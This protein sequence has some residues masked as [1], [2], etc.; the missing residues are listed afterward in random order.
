MLGIALVAGFAAAFAVARFPA[1]AADQTVNATAG[2]SWDPPGEVAITAGDTITWA[3]PSGGTHNVCVRPAADSSGC[4]TFRNGAPSGDWSAYT[5]EHKFTVANQSY[6]FRCE[7]HPGMTGTI[8]VGDGSPSTTTGTTPT[9]TTNAT[10]TNTTTTSASPT[11][12]LTADTTAP[13]FVGTIR[14][15]SSRKMLRLSFKVSENGTLTATLRRRPPGRKSFAFVSKTT[16]AVT[17]GSNTISFLRAGRKLRAG[18]YR[19]T[20]VLKDSA[21][22]RSA[23]KVLNFKLT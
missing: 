20:L 11:P 6:T 12:T 14:R 5:N 19:L 9:T 4:A 21:A 1:L 17:L 2:N 15:R 13:R 16:K 18:A 7:A 22:N 23:P 3:N 10:T 8:K